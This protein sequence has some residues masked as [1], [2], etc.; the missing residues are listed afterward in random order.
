MNN[1][2]SKTQRQRQRET[3]KISKA[4]IMAVLL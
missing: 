2:L 1:I 4:K 3:I